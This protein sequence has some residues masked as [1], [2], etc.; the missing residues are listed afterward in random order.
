[1]SAASNVR[2]RRGGPRPVQD[3]LRTIVQGQSNLF[4]GR[5]PVQ[6]CLAAAMLL[7]CPTAAG[8]VW[9]SDTLADAPGP[10]SEVM[11]HFRTYYFDR[12]NPG[13]VTNAAW[14]MREAGSAI[15]R[16][17]L[18]TALRFGA[19]GY[20]SQ[21]LWG[22]LDKEGSGLLAPPQ[23]SYSVIGEAFVSLKLW[24]QVLT[25]GR[26]LLNQPEINASDNR[27]TPITYSGGNLAG[28][29]AGVDYTLAFLNA[30]K[31]K[32]SE[33][34]VNFVSAAGIDSN[35]SEPLWL[36]GAAGA[37]VTR[38]ELAVCPATTCPTCSAPPTPTPAG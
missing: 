28:K 19:I 32:T 1:M 26:F 15:K 22:P 6:R 7:V 37:A 23:Q 3:R 34:F 14:A 36:A 16:A 9:A 13:D 31:P 10:D 12:L 20:T 18:P 25:G 8:P 33:R 4:L 21:R 11:L 30:T 27:M 2:R 17:G 5:S 38:V 24:D 35:A 29:V